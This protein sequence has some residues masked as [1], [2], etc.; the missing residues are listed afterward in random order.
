MKKK[1]V[2]ILLFV[3]PNLMSCQNLETT[4][5]ANME[6]D[7]KAFDQTMQPD[8]RGIITYDK[9]QVVWGAYYSKYHSG[10]CHL[11]QLHCASKVPTYQQYSNQCH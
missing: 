1:T 3:L 9:Y 10:L 7:S 5:T 8:V 6:I 2:I 4:E 11:E